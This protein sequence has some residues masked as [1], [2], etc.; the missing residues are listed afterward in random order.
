MLL[1]EILV[2]FSMHPVENSSLFPYIYFFIVP[3]FALKFKREGVRVVILI[4]VDRLSTIANIK[5]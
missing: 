5:F 1:V 2:I 4:P 3:D